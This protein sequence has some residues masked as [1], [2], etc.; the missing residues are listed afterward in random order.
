MSYLTQQ[1]IDA[2]QVSELHRKTPFLIANCQTSVFSIA[3]HYGGAR[4]QGYEYVYIPTTDELIRQDV[5]K[6]LAKYRKEQKSKEI[7]IE[8]QGKLLL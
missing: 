6:W 2:L 1:E 8:T 3:R 5:L 7:D 4:Y